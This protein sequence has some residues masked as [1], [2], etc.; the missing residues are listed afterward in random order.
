M[1]KAG[2]P[3]NAKAEPLTAQ[4]ERDL[5]LIARNFAGCPDDSAGDLEKQFGYDEFIRLKSESALLL[6]VHY[7]GCESMD[8]FI[9]HCAI[10]DVFKQEAEAEAAYYRRYA[11]G[12]HRIADLLT[13]AITRAS[14]D[15][16]AEVADLL[17]GNGGLAAKIVEIGEALSRK[18]LSD[19]AINARHDKEGGSR[20]ARAQLR[21]T[22]AQGN[23]ST[24]VE[25]A[26][27]ER[28]RFKGVKG[29]ELSLSQALKYLRNT[30][31]PDPWPA[32]PKRKGGNP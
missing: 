11:G 13:I 27:Q 3:V 9:E 29:K 20:D 2:K 32:D 4:Q 5:L 1:S 15:T 6:R 7:E 21:T 14:D 23:F 31:D 8:E 12:L 19:K 16:K 17:T 22:W 30:P 10:I 18:R 24:R 28:G 26:E 25:C